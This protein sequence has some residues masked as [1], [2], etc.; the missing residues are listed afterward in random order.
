MKTIAYY[1]SDYGYGHATRSIAIIRKLIE[2]DPKVKIMI[3]HSFAMKFIKES[4]S[5]NRISFRTLKTDVGY[6]LKEESIQPDKD[7]LNSEF[8]QFTQNWEEKIEIEK[9]FLQNN[10]IDL[11]I[12][13]I[14]PLPFEAAKSLGIPSIGLSNFTWYT[15]YQGL[16]E[17][18]SLSVYKQAYQK[19]T[20]FFSLAGSNESWGKDEKPFYFFSRVREE[21]EVQRIR[22]LVD[23]MGNK[24]V[25]FV[26]LGMKI[27]NEMIEHFSFW[28]SK[29]CVFITSS[30]MDIRKDNVYSIP[31]DYLESQNYIAASDL[32]ISKAGWGMASEAVTANIP[33]LLINRKTMNEDQNTIHYLK[34][35]NLCETVEWDDLRT[36]QF[37][38]ESIIQ[39]KKNRDSVFNSD[40]TETIATEILKLLID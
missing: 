34:E 19:M 26:G 39:M 14:S 20:Y 25:L 9:T 15:A 6:I 10:K 3:C 8:I 11:V 23:P 36:L 7:K 32:V 30:N 17:E 33:L 29:D 27:D 5:T 1:I 40:N 21:K 22:K 12:S 38:N 35:R 4:L 28:D 16:I 24:S 31:K 13:D 37:N 2:M 18:Q